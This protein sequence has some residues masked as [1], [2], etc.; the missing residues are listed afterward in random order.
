MNGFRIAL[1]GLFTWM[2]LGLASQALA[3]DPPKSAQAA[4]PEF[5]TI[6]M[7]YVDAVAMTPTVEALIRP[8]E[9][10]AIPVP[11]MNAIIVSGPK[12]RLAEARKLVEQLD[13][14]PRKAASHQQLRVFTLKAIP[15]DKNLENALSVIFAG[16]QGARFAID[17]V[18]NQVI[19]YC[20]EQTSDMVTALLSKLD[21]TPER[22]PTFD[23]QIRVI[24][25]VNG[26]PEENAPKLPDDLGPVL[27]TLVRM[28]IDKPVLAAQTM[29]VTSIENPFVAK[30]TARV[31]QGGLCDF[32]VTGF[33]RDNKD[34][35]RLS[36]NLQAG[37]ADQARPAQFGGENR[38][39]DILHL[40]TEI[41]A[42][43]GHIVVL[44]M[45]PTANLTS[46]F[47]VQIQR[48]EPAAGKK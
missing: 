37:R 22:Q 3:A 13:V 31:D 24:W 1:V 16:R 33:A 9:C 46:V 19:V 42:P 45:T 15:T 8:L 7:K 32:S 43:M 25:L 26:A 20:D 35:S 47:L 29:V 30:G 12:D 39:Q 40:E 14:E 2:S 44:G 6:P 4:S 11:H 21:S 48:A 41:A 28:G 34:G 17:P 18:R 10:I 27:R 36:L 5:A 23:V 38:R